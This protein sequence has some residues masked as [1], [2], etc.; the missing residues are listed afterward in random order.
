MREKRGREQDGWVDIAT[1][2]A[3]GLMYSVCNGVNQVHLLI[4]CLFV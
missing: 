3:R 2:N 1:V 4:F